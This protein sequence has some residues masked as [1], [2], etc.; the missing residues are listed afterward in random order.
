MHRRSALFITLREEAT[1]QT[2]PRDSQWCRDSSMAQP[3]RVALTDTEWFSGSALLAKKALSTT[4]L[5]VLMGRHPNP[6]CF[7][8]PAAYTAQHLRAAPPRP[9]RFSP[10]HRSAKRRFFTALL[11]EQTGR[12]PRAAW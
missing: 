6:G 8:T 4:S 11:A 9:V 1:A 12:V 10:L 3:A 5:A 2:R 7:T